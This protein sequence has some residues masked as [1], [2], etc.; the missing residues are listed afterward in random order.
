MCL[1]FT[2]TFILLH[3]TVLVSMAQLLDTL[4]YFL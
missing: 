3:G 1:G 4:H 2:F